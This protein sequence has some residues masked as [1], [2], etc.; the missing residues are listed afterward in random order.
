MD[1]DK[2]HE[3]LA[4]L[5]SISVEIAGLHELDEIQDRVL[6]YCLD[7]TDS[8][9][10]FTGLLRSPTL[11]GAAEEVDFSEAEEVDLSEQVMD[12]AAIKGF[13][14]DPLFYQSFRF[15]FLRSSVVGVVIKENRSHLANDVESDPHSLGRP[16]GHPPI[17]KFLGVPLRLGEAVIGMI[18]VANKKDDY[19]SED[20]RLLSTFAAH[21][22]V[23][24][25]NARLYEQ[26]RQMIGE[27]QELRERL[28]ESERMKLLG[29][30]RQRIAGALH[31]RID[32]QI[33]MIGV[34]LN[35]LL[36]QGR[37]DRGL[38]E[39]LGELRQLSIKASDEI[40]RA[41]FALTNPDRIGSDFI[42]YM[43]W[44]LADLRRNSGIR[45]HLSVSGVPDPEHV[46]AYDVVRAAFD[47]AISNVR[48]HADARM[49]LVSVR[50]EP[51][52]V[53]LVVQDDGVGVPEVVLS[54]IPN[55]HRTSAC[56]TYVSSSSTGEESS[57]SSMARRPV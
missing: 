49:V 25:D 1:G 13:N 6:G 7:L 53:D 51:A 22:A 14:P 24:V 5:Y 52:R 39:Q 38:A 30:E 57:K 40:R 2:L 11:D 36:D 32:Q 27:L 19:D 42:D 54:A 34:R 37:L 9:F 4:S 16:P 41:I 45:T 29:E 18:G 28:T 46:G 31:D 47:E 21:A 43:R 8:Q 12:V 55:S 44:M 48:K 23:A 35:A 26:Q 3:Q 50:F 15:M 17:Q 56:D 33:F 20:E 10:A